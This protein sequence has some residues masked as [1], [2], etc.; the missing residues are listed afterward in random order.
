M[1]NIDS[2]ALSNYFFEKLG[3][4]KNDIERSLKFEVG[5]SKFQA[6][7]IADFS[8]PKNGFGF[9]PNIVLICS[10]FQG[11]FEGD[12]CFVISKPNIIKLINKLAG[13]ETSDSEVN[14]KP[15]MTGVLLEVANIVFT[16]VLHSFFDKSREPLT[17]DIPAKYE[18]ITLEQFVRNRS[19]EFRHKLITN[20]TMKFPKANIQAELILMF[21]EKSLPGLNALIKS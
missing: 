16:K 4:N 12:A 15:I 1:K 10:S 7:Y 2:Q 17:I 20:T 19:K 14:Y 3:K 8:N 11:K 6:S 5:F 9:N 21:N 13:E 18:I